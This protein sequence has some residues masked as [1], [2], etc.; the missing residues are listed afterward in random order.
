MGHIRE[1]GNTV[2]QRHHRLAYTGI[3]AAAVLAV[4]LLAL[5]FP[6]F[7]DAYDQWGWQIKCGTGYLTDLTQAA[8]SVCDVNY[9]EE[10][11]S[12]LL[13]RRMWTV[14]LVL[15]GATV[16]L[17]VLVASATSSARETLMAY[18]ETA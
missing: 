4:G 10:C 18:R 16:G 12:A 13:M 17:V 9:V 1:R 3:A 7:L 2:P 8:A 15:V 11:E 6:V 14:P 5:N